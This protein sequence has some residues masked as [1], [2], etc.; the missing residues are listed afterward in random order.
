[1]LG[2]M[3]NHPLLISSLIEHAA[4]AH[5]GGEVV[6]RM[7]DGSLR[8]HR[9]VAIHQRAKQV[10]NALTDLGVATGER[11]GTLAWNGH[12]HL[13]L[14][15]AV[16]GMGAVLHTVNPRLFPQQI[17][18]IV[19]HAGD[20][21]LLFDT[22]FLP[23]VEQLAPRLESVRRFIALTDAAHMPGSSL[24][25]L[26]CY[27]EWIADYGSD[28]R[29]PTLDENLASSM[30]YTS[31]T[32]G[33]P[34]GVLFTHRSTLLHTMATCR[35]DGLGISAA[36]AVLLATPMFH[37]NGWGLPY[38]AALCGANLLLP[39][40]ALDGASLYE[41]LKSERATVG[42][43]VPTVWMTLQQYVEAQGLDPA[44]E[45]ELRRVVIGGSAVPRAMI[46][47]FER[48]FHASIVHAW[49]M[50]ETSPLGT[51]SNLLRKHRDAT[52]EQRIELL[53]KQGRA[54]FG[55]EL[56]IV[57]LEDR[58]LPRDGKTP[59]RLLIRGHWVASAYFGGDAGSALDPQGWFDTGD[60][61]T[62]D[63]DGYVQITDRA[64]DV[65]KSG[66][67]WISSIDLENAA[68]CHPA[69]AEAAAIGIPDPKWQERPLLVVVRKPRQELTQASLREFLAARVAKWWLPERVV[70]VSELPHTATG[71]LQKSV[72]RQMYQSGELDA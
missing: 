72:L 30:C 7:E 32:T 24:P 54:P 5:P 41:L 40:S 10:A 66:G 13:E 55:V 69:V 50:T 1:M 35:T 60:I 34:K 59:G 29:W 14:I 46:E 33:H 63:S 8:R 39:G 3:Q 16:S 62:I 56:R 67:E 49:G 18:Y 68:V 58:D 48:D 21:C 25:H 53:L 47:R 38:A 4:N 23:L 61:A 71:K 65:I 17:E 6:S 22:G 44:N 52:P 43:G 28:Y 51:V 9:Y 45:L 26:A 31:G 64:K 20:R 57:D 2:L 42:A 12:R 11:I 15:F 27:E 70:F 19:N 36:D 37:A